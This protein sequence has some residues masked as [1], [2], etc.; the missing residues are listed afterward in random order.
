[1]YKCEAFN[2]VVRQT[3]GGSYHQLVVQQGQYQLALCHY[4]SLPV[5]DKIYWAMPPHQK[6]SMRTHMAGKSR[7]RRRRVGLGM[8]RNVPSQPTRMSGE[9]SWAPQWGLGRN[10][11]GNAFWCILK[12]TERSFL[13]IYADAL[14][15][16]NSVL[17]HILAAFDPLPFTPCPPPNVEP[18]PFTVYAYISIHY[19]RWA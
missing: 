19:R 14:G 11:A 5:I 9:A 12:A 13:H 7:G 6:K 17:S 16:S 8:G 1:M 3:T 2:Y 10:P 18:R 15:S 4:T